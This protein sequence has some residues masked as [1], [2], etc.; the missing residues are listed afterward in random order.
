MLNASITISSKK[1]RSL[2]AAL[3]NGLVLM[4]FSSLCSQKLV[5]KDTCPWTGF[6]LIIHFS[7]L[8]LP[9][10]THMEYDCSNMLL[11]FLFAFDDKRKRNC[12]EKGLRCHLR[13]SWGSA[14]TQLKLVEVIRLSFARCSFYDIICPNFYQALN[15]FFVSSIEVG[16]LFIICFND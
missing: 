15:A 9:K 6:M 2:L 11:W 13:W 1:K 5:L 10:H 7:F 8:N 14:H 3:S 12:N 4:V 16:R